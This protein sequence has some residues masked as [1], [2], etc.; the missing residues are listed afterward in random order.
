M[1][2]PGGDTRGFAEKVFCRL[3]DYALLIRIDRPIGTLLLLWPTLWALW[4]AGRGHPDAQVFLVFVAGVFLMRSAGCAINDFADRDIDPHVKRTE[5]RPLASGRVSPAEALAIATL[6]AYLAFQLVLFLNM[7]TIGL[8]MI[9]VFLAAS[10]PFVKRFTHLPQFYLG[11]A[12]GWAVPMGF[13]AQTGSVPLL[14]WLIF[15]AVVLWAA[16]YDTM[17]AM[18]DRED[19][20]RI[21]VRS[22]AI[23]FGPYDRFAIGLC[24]TLTLLLLAWIGPLAE[25]GL[26][27]SAGLLAAAVTAIWQQWLI[28]HRFPADCFRAF[29]N[30][31]QFGLFIFCGILLSYVFEPV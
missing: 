28:R 13:A 31:N 14:A 12:F 29:L 6:L 22:T 1:P 10:Y 4:I 21:G 16:A 27:Y 17:Y 30:N 26:W 23:L 24:Q 5:Q 15:L 25:L 8:S 9:G 18:V 3:R 20:L 11:V 7:L 2:G 19:D